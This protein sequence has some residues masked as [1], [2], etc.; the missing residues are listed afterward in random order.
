M[1]ARDM[2]THSLSSEGV[3]GMVGVISVLLGMSLRNRWIS[4]VDEWIVWQRDGVLSSGD[5]E[6]VFHGTQQG[7]RKNLDKPILQGG[8]LA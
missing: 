7:T 8:S 3:A 6:D 5:D 2:P 1:K 4:L